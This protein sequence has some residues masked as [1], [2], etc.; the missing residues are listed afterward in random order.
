MDGK[1]I[2]VDS[3]SYERHKVKLILERTGDFDV[4]EVS[5]LSQFILLNLDI[6]DLKL[7]II[8]ISFP[9]ESDGF[10][11]LQHLKD[12]MLLPKTPVIVTTRLDLPD[13]KAAALKF[14]VRDYIIKPYQ[15]K[16]LED[17]IR[18]IVVK[19]EKDFEYDASGIGNIKMTFDDYIKRELNF[20]KRT[21]SPLSFVLITLLNIRE[22]G[23]DD[24]AVGEPE[25]ESIYSIAAGIAQH[26][27][28]L[29][30]TII[31]NKSRDIIIV[32][33]S[34]SDNGAK[35]VCDKI[36][37]QVTD[38]LKKIN[39]DYNNYI[40]LVNF[41]YPKDGYDFQTLMKTAYQKVSDKE[42]LE[43]IVSIKASEHSYASKRYSR[44]NKL[45]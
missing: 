7:V 11:A 31:V 18:G 40:Y 35:L 21:Q 13:V 9:T 23:T 37:T 44:F 22:Q 25:K 15:V 5:N 2:I 43:K 34:T 16:R 41:S 4:I 17:S 36:R 6:E 39:P 27:L 26:A 24:A 32:L 1:V 20:A 45:S 10:T 12:K 42:M 28:R 29:T 8:D 30:D 38:A 3:S 33:P 14:N 19:E